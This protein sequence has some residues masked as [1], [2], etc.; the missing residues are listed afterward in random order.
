MTSRI[1]KSRIS[2]LFKSNLRFLVKKFHTLQECFFKSLYITQHFYVMWT[3]T[4]FRCSLY[5][6]N[7]FF[8]RWVLA[9]TKFHDVKRLTDLPCNTLEQNSVAERQ[10]PFP[11]QDI[12]AWAMKYFS[13][14]CNSLLH[15]LYTFFFSFCNKWVRYPIVNIFFYDM[16]DRSWECVG[17]M[18]LLP[19]PSL[20]LA[21]SSPT[22]LVR[23]VSLQH[24]LLTLSVQP[25]P[26]QIL[27]S[28]PSHQFY[29]LEIILGPLQMS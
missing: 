16:T 3:N 27:L 19:P 5:T 9:K 18:F 2:T 7:P 10:N 11:W 23:I 15:S 28:R 20:V 17:I 21:V 24:L 29:C 22:L 12:R 1:F 14:T 8:T 26:N 6:F 25:S 13:P 4:D